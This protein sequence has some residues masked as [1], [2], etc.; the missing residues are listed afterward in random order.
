VKILAKL[1]PTLSPAVVASAFKQGIL[2]VARPIITFNSAMW[3]SVNSILVSGGTISKPLDT[4]PNTT[5]TN[6]YID[7]A[8]ANV[9]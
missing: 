5:W 2:P 9:F 4:A 1:Y 8:Q 3:K 7:E 6:K